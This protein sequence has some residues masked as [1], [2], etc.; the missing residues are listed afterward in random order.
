MGDHLVMLCGK[1]KGKTVQEIA[2]VNPDYLIY[3]YRNSGYDGKIKNWVY[4][5]LICKK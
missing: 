5:N 2:Q 1:Y 3:I 4:E